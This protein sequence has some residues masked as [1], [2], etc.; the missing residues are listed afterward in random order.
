MKSDHLQ[1][2]IPAAYLVR[3]DV[4][5]VLFNGCA[6]EKS[7]LWYPLHA[8]AKLMRKVKVQGRYF[9]VICRE[10]CNPNKRLSCNMRGHDIGQCLTRYKI[11]LPRSDESHT[12]SI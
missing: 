3:G 6:T 11:V 8:L 2:E 9:S 5:F 1:E 10:W 7:D 12:G 4:C